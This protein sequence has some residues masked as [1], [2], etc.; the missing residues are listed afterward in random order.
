MASL[1][2]GPASTTCAEPLAQD[3]DGVVVLAESLGRAHLVDD[4]QVAALARQLPPAVLEDGGLVVA[5]LG[6]EADDDG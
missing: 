4:E 6:G 3:V 5:G 1:D 2:A